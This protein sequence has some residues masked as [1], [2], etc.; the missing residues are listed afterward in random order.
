[1]NPRITTNGS[2]TDTAGIEEPGTTYG[3]AND[4]AGI[5]GPSPL[6][7]RGIEQE[8]EMTK[9][10]AVFPRPAHE[11]YPSGGS[12]M[13]RAATRLLAEGVSLAEDAVAASDADDFVTAQDIILRL[14][15]LMPELFCCRSLGD[16]YGAIINAVMY[17]LENLGTE[18]ASDEQMR[19]IRWILQQVKTH[20]FLSHNVA[21]DLIMALEDGGL[22]VEPEEF[23]HLN[24]M[25]DE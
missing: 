23:Q 3:S 19:L 18:P 2:V 24:D 22:V 10:E 5:E 20:P 21:V 17:G 6:V 1:M 25:I 8:E 16:G 13:L 12:P 4:T 7:L 11:F 14:K 9:E 15:A